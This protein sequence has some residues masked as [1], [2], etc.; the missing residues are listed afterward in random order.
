MVVNC[1]EWVSMRE[2][3]DPSSKQLVKVPL[4]AIV[5]SCVAYLDSYILCEYKSYKGYIST[6]YLKKANYSASSQDQSVV[7]KSEGKY[8]PIT[9]PMVVVNCNDWV[10]LREKASTSAARLARVPLGAQVTGCV[11]VS[12]SFIYCS[13]GGLWGYI[14]VDYLSEPEGNEPGFPI[15]SGFSD[16][17]Y[18]PSMDEFSTAPGYELLAEANQGYTIVV[19]THTSENQTE[20]MAVCYN[21]SGAPQWELRDSSPFEPADWIL[22]DAFIGGVPEDPLL[23]WYVAGKGFFAYEY[24][25]L[26]KMRWTLP[27]SEPLPLS[28]ALAR[29]VDTDGVLYL[30]FEDEAM[31]ISQDGQLRWRTSCD[32]PNIYRP[33]TIEIGDYYFD[34]TYENFPDLDNV[35]TVVRFSKD[36]FLLMN[37]VKV[38]SSSE[39]DL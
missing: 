4:G 16:I 31:S 28:D 7:N 34:V 37:T 13:Y 38:I 33:S 21:P 5:T 3:P 14:H 25:P 17:P 27:M 39:G 11:Q 2:G 24:G 23:I 20:M 19:R 26:L 30:A 1:S 29:A 15:E 32:D 12:D 22:A 9:G 8:P 36:G 6:T 10:S 35:V 18:L